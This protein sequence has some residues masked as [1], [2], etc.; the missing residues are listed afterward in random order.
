MS[1]AT[2]AIVCSLAGFVLGLF[3]GT[4]VYGLHVTW[5]DRQYWLHGYD[6]RRKR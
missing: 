3:V 6:R 4:V 1:L 5:R 2:F